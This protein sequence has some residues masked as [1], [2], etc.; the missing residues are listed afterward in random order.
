MRSHFK[1]CSECASISEWRG[2]N[3]VVN[4]QLEIESVYSTKDL[5]L[6][7]INNYGMD[8]TVKGFVFKHPKL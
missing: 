1:P 6:D 3:S 4:E 7:L 8:F 5:D 2:V